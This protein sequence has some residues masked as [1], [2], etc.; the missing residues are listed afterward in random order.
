MESDECESTKLP[1]IRFGTLCTDMNS[2]EHEQ[3]KTLLQLMT[4]TINC[5]YPLK[6]TAIK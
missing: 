4:G 5:Y 3:Q 2:Q 6:A 1:P